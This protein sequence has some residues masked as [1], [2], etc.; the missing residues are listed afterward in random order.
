MWKLRQRV[1]LV[2]IVAIFTHLSYDFAARG[3]TDRDLDIIDG[4]KAV[5]QFAHDF[6]G[7]NLQ[8]RES[9]DNFVYS[10]YSLNQL[11]AMLSFGAAGTTKEQFMRA[12]GLT[13]VS[14]STV[15]LLYETI[16]QRIGAQAPAT[17]VGNKNGHSNIIIREASK[18]WTLG[19]VAAPKYVDKM[20]R[21]F[22][23]DV[24]SVEKMSVSAINAYVSDHTAGK[25]PKLFGD[26]DKNTVMVIVHALYLKA[27]WQ[28][29]FTPRG[30]ETFYVQEGVPGGTGSS[31]TGAEKVDMMMVTHRF[32]V[33]QTL[34][35]EAVRVPLKLGQR[36]SSS[37]KK[38]YSMIFILPPESEKARQMAGIN[39]KL[40]DLNPTKWTTSQRTEVILP[41]FNITSRMNHLKE[42][43]KHDLGLHIFEGDNP[44]FSKL[45]DKVP[46]GQLYV[47]Q[48]V[49]EA[50]IELNE[51][52]V[53]AAAASGVAM[54]TTSIDIDEP[55]RMRFNRPFI[56][57][58][59]DD[60][61]E[62]ELFRGFVGNPASD[63]SIKKGYELIDHG[64]SSTSPLFFAFLVIL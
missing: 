31:P 46:V 26:L 6:W 23:S 3:E 17:G 36:S 20:K 35:G 34:W 33:A 30:K 15:E 37:G 63:G 4:I 59:I 16:N 18:I 47:S 24:E 45:S 56:F 62:M 11:F 32:P 5:N 53:E 19:D 22:S 25:I 7:T 40:E 12:L 50:V 55:V 10:P 43:T 57:L 38:G 27:K 1:L 61:L 42:V 14:E 64:A 44:D 54:S 52:G 21:I 29:K 51:D 41:K 48:I 58:I 9:A 49:H 8:K 60:E 2:S 39:F 13:G 28:V